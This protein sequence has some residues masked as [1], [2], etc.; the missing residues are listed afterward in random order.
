MLWA[1]FSGTEVIAVMTA[2]L[3]AIAGAVVTVMAARHKHRQEADQGAIAQWRELHRLQQEQIDRQERH[4]AGLD[5]LI[6]E[7]FAADA[8]CQVELTRQY[9]LLE[10]VHG[11]LARCKEALARQGEDVGALPPLPPPPARRNRRA[12]FLTRQAAQD[13]ATLAEVNKVIHAQAPP[14]GGT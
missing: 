11:T 8:E 12:E 5:A 6:G 1:E 14:G 7:L 2:L 3:T 13:S 9:G 4:I 10:W